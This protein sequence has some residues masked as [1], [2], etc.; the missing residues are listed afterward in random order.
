MSKTKETPCKYYVCKGECEKGRDADH[1]KYCQK[2]KLYVARAKVKHINI[3]KQ[4]L[5]KIRE[6]EME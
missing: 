5:N 3:K 6:K 2:C 4:K 1:E